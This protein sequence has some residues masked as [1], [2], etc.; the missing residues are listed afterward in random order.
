[1][2]AEIYSKTSCPYCIRAKVLLSQKNIPY[3]EHI[4]SGSITKADIEKKLKS[5]G[6]NTEVKTVPQIFYTDKNN[7]V[8]YI[9]G[10]TELQANQA[11]L[12]T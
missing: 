8:H 3:Q 5:L 9:G 12:G 4:L 2:S 7:K 1:M 10:Y 6:I 11:I